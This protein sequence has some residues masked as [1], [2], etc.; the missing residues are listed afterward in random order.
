MADL[1]G[2]L[3]G[4]FIGLT[5]LHA[6]F[7]ADPERCSPYEPSNRQHLNPL[8]IAV[9]RLPGFACS[10][11]LER[12]LARLRQ[13]DLVDYA[14]VAQIKLRVL[15]DL[16][17]KPGDS[18]IPMIRPISTLLSRKA[19]T[20]CGCTRFSNASLFQW[21]SAG[22]ALTGNGGLADFQRFDSAA[23]AEFE[24]GHAEDVRFHMWLQWLAHR[25]LMQAAD[26][27]GKG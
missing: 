8:Y 2:S 9:D 24:R 19:V 4:D 18:A 13:T 3:G 26:R 1:L 11:E 6:P 22:Q 16:W 12:Q 20:A 10:P 7:L 21:S 27:A 25:Q 15:R 17:P 5:P 14:G 23:V